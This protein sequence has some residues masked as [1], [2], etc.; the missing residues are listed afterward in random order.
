MK[1]LLAIAAVLG[2]ASAAC[3]NQ[4]S[5]HGRCGAND[6][7]ICNHQVGTDNP[8]RLAYTGVDCSLRTCPL[9]KAYDA[10]STQASALGAISFMPYSTN[11][12]PAPK[13]RAFYN[14]GLRS[15]DFKKMR[16]DQKFIVK[17]MSVDWTSGAEKATFTWKYDEDEYFGPES[18]LDL[19]SSATT[20][21]SN[22]NLSPEFA[23]HLGTAAKASGV[24]VYFDATAG[25]D[26]GW[27]SST[28]SHIA[29]GDVYS[30]T[31]Q[32]N[33]QVDFDQSDSN[34]AHQW[35]ECS[36]RGTCDYASGKCKCIDG[37]TGEACQRTAC[38]NSCS[39]HG[40][41]Q[42]EERFVKDAA[43]GFKYEAYDSAQQYGCR[44]DDGYRG[45]DCSQIECP[46]GADILGGD[47]GAAGMDCS[48]RGLCDYSTGV[49][50]CHKGYYGERC[51]SQTNFS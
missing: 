18:S 48:G 45:A 41:C 49:C 14:S 29:A 30:F 20:G 6:K 1:S 11:K 31:L 3:P 22:A 32:W 12:S 15:D 35:T 21:F 39:G 47:G 10:I 2:L 13:L 51:E 28:D 19:R 16:R 38:P 37:Y 27:G 43:T 42:S 17:V 25:G 44:C 50:K 4:C 24:F 34:T 8:Y 36:G 5:G 33:D 46:S 23:L 40:Q 9:G 7:C 26:S